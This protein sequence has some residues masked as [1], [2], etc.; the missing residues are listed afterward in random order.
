M[1]SNSSEIIGIRLRYSKLCKTKEEKRREFKE[2][3]YSFQK[4]LSKIFSSLKNSIDDETMKKE[5]E[6]MKV[7]WDFESKIYS[8]LHPK[9]EKELTEKEMWKLMIKEAII[10]YKLKSMRKNKEGMNLYDNSFPTKNESIFNEEL[11]ELNLRISLLGI[12]RTKRK[13]EK[14]KKRREK[15]NENNSNQ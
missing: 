14:I 9:E 15:K 8:L 2:M 7:K 13:Q 5:I 1:D 12:E 10:K 4:I 3:A 11:Y 6:E